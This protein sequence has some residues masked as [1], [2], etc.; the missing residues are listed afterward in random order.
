MSAK[1][2]LIVPD[3]NQKNWALVIKGQVPTIEQY[4]RDPSKYETIEHGFYEVFAPIEDTWTTDNGIYVRSDK[5]TFKV[6][7]SHFVMI[8][9]IND[10]NMKVSNGMIWMKGRFDKKG[11]E[12]LFR[13]GNE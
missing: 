7:F 8:K 1:L 13:V 5:G 4:K 10:G 9:Q 6:F 3:E 12:I 11:A 2:N